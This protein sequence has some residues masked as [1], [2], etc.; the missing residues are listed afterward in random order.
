MS[1]Q[2]NYTTF[3]NNLANGSEADEP[4]NLPFL[5]RVGIVLGKAK[6]HAEEL[7]RYIPGMDNVLDGVHLGTSKVRVDSVNKAK[8]RRAKKARK[9]AREAAKQRPVDV[10]DDTVPI[11]NEAGRTVGTKSR[12]G[13][14]VPG[15]PGVKEFAL[16][17]K[18]R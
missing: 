15:N 11:V 17:R 1:W 6:G 18:G 3:L 10:E 9:E 5:G 4:T 7:V 8:E 16:G 2:Q 12:R 14:P 13:K